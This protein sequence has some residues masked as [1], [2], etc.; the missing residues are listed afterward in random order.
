MIVRRITAGAAGLALIGTAFAAA[1][2]MAK[3]NTTTLKLDSGLVTLLTGANITP[4]PIKPAKLKGTTVTFKAKMKGKT[5][6]HKGGLKLTASS[7]AVASFS[8]IA[9]NAKNGKASALVAIPIAPDGAVVEDVLKFSGGKNKLKKKG[10]WKNA[11]V[12]LG[13]ETAFGDP[14]PL[15][16]DALGLPSTAIPSGVTLGKAT[17]VVKVK[18]KK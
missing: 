3:T 12:T 11:K 15:L 7:G 8:N 18:K 5:V 17:I 10:T 13:T 2:A 14:A 4:S 9:I 16:A 6:T 1:P